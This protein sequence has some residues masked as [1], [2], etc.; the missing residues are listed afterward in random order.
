MPSPSSSGDTQT[1]VRYL[2]STLRTKLAGRNAL[3]S[4]IGNTGWL[5]VDRVLQMAIGLVVSVWV[6]RYLGPERLGIYRYSVS[7]LA[8]FGYVAEMGLNGIAVRE[9]VEEKQSK[10]EII[11]TVFSVK[12]IAGVLSTAGVLLTVYLIEPDSALTRV[13]TAIIS[14]RLI[15]QAVNTL[16]IWFRAQVQSKYTVMAKSTAV[17]SAAC[18]KIVLILQ[19]APLLAFAWVLLAETAIYAAVLTIVYYTTGNRIRLISPSLS[20]AKSLLSRSWPLILSGFGSIVYLKVDQ[21]MLG[22]MASKE[23]V[24]IYSVAAQLS[25]VW[26]FIPTA[27]TASVFPALLK[28]RKEDRSKYNKRLQ[29]LYDFM[30]CGS[31]CVAVP[32]AFLADWGINLLYGVSYDRAAPIL[33]IHIWASAFIFMRAILSKWL[34][35]ED[36]YMFSLVTH[37]TGAVANVAIN[38]VLIPLYGGIGA[39]VA[40]VISYAAASY[41]ALFLHRKTWPAAGMMTRAIVAPV[42]WGYAL[43]R[44]S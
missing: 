29:Q 35:A 6:A 43:I 13:F 32:V 41:F 21:I 34:I 16:D 23:E 19:E 42:R 26:Y 36:L 11:S 12:L 17:V 10:D 7:L 1:W 18:V 40:T 5:F 44:R 28:T 9:L 15:L 30:F 37:G 27:I 33:T 8:L 22:N 24:G 2:P 20:R 3:R 14:L 38:I 4:A 25:E 39:A 31:L